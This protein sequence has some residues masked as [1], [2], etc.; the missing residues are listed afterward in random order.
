VEIS[1]ETWDRSW[2]EVGRHERSKSN[3]G[4]TCVLKFLETHGLLIGIR[5]SLP[6]VHVVNDGRSFSSVGLSGNFTTV[7]DGL[8]HTAKDD[9]LGPPL[10]VGLHDS[11]DWVGGGN[12]GGLEHTNLG[13]PEPANSGKHG[14][15]SIG[16]L[17]LAGMF[18]RDPVGKV[19][20]I[21]LWVVVVVLGSREQKDKVST[22]MIFSTR[23]KLLD[24]SRQ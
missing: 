20:R 3:H 11:I 23:L 1:R 4:K 16:K 13:R 21:E 17:S 7:L 2:D 5:Q 12:I 6:S 14:G 10:W 8:N 18:S 19:Q 15:A 9:K 22:M 24:G